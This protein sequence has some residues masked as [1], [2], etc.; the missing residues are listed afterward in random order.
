VAVKEVAVKEAFGQD[1]VLVDWPA[2]ERRVAERRCR[3]A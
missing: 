1:A 3:G 2:V